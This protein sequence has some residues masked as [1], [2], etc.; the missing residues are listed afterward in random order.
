[1]INYSFKTVFLAP[2]NRNA[3]TRVIAH[4][5]LKLRL[6]LSWAQLGC[7]IPT[8]VGV[9]SLLDTVPISTGTDIKPKPLL[10][11]FSAKGIC[12]HSSKAGAVS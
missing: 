4:E 7:F 2:N 10:I 6:S 9:H 11:A 12:K 5:M 8:R 3:Q 1:M